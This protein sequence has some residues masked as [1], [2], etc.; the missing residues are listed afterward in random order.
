MNASLD[1]KI[2]AYTVCESIDVDGDK[3]LAYFST[4]DGKVTRTNVAGTG[5]YEGMVAT[6]NSFEDLGPF[7]AIKDGTFQ[8]CNHQTGTYKL[9]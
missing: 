9:K 8:N 3:R 5:K 4:A 7:P 1:G 2:T 6:Q